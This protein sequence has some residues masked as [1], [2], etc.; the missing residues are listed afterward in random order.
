MITYEFIIIDS[1]IARALDVP[2]RHDIVAVG[3]TVHL[4]GLD[5]VLVDAHLLEF[6]C[7]L[8]CVSLRILGDISAQDTRCHT[9]TT[10][11]VFFPASLPAS[12]SQ[13]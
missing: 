13:Q 5:V 10:R 4:C 2:G 6:A 9:Q 3:L 1:A 7:A 11:R 12:Y 8:G